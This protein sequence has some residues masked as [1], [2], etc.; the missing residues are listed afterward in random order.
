MREVVERAGQRY[1][2]EVAAD[3]A[4]GDARGYQADIS[5][6]FVEM[7]WQVSQP[8]ILGIGVNPRSGL[9]VS[10][11][12]PLPPEAVVLVDAFRAAQ[13]EFDLYKN[14]PRGTSLLITTPIRP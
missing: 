5:R 9:A 14:R 11:A 10:T 6:L 12:D 13:V 8:M 2:I 3:G 4:C 7:G 1:L